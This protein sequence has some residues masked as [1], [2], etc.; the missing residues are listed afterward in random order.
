MLI[1][2]FLLRQTRLP[3]HLHCLRGRDGRV[4]A[5]A[6][7]QGIDRS[8]HCSDS[9]S[10]SIG[11]NVNYNGIKNSSKGTARFRPESRKSRDERHRGKRRTE[12][13]HATGYWRAPG[14][15]KR[16]EDRDRKRDRGLKSVD[17]V[18][19]PRRRHAKGT[20]SNCKSGKTRY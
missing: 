18:S 17:D 9:V 14:G 4:A 12:W 1:N 20:I 11:R 7:T 13:S 19:F 3:F 15:E 10:L 8:T 16:G 2:F 5:R 6:T